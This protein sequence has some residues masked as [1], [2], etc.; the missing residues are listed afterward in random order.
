MAFPAAPPVRRLLVTLGVIVLTAVGAGGAQSDG[1]DPDAPA[2]ELRLVADGLAVPVFLTEPDDG[3]GRLFVV[4]QVGQ[5]RIVEDGRLLTAPFLDVSDRIV[6]LDPN[7]DERGL[8]GLAFHPEFADNGRFFVYYSAS[9]RDEAP[10]GWDH[11]SHLSEFRV[12]DDPNRADPDSERLVLAV[13]QPF[14]NHNAGHIVFGRDGH[15]YVPL[16]DGGN[17]GDVDPPDDDRGRPDAGHGQTTSTL[18]GSILRLDVDAEPDD[19]GYG[20]PDDNPFVDEEPLDEIWAYGFRNPYGLSLDLETGDLYAADAGQALY[21]ELNRVEPGGNHGWNIKEGT[22]CFDPDDFLDPPATCP[23]SGADGEPLI[24]PIVEYRR[25]P[26]DGSVIVAG[27]RYRG[28]KLRDFRGQLLFGD[29]GAIRFLPSGILYAAE[30]RDEGLWEHRRVRIATPLDGR[31]DGE[32]HRWVL[33]VSQDLD[34]EA[35]LLTSKEGGPTGT[36]GEVF[37]LEPVGGPVDD[38]WWQTAW[39]WVVLGALGVLGVAL[40]VSLASGASPRRSLRGGA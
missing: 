9:L 28:S 38:P 35:Y 17:G 27:I 4:D 1:A 32:L 13:D 8:L 15:L 21:E 25:S 18:L 34:G 22:G 5:V 16:G 29:Y 30:P 33:A 6:E 31:A 10:D 40:L 7:Y 36:T 19:G 11:T 14:R 26:E 24:D 2:V 23:D 3:S 20:I 37:A 12:S 39:I